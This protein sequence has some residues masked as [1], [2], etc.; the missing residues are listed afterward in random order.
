M[1][2]PPQLRAQRRDLHD[3]LRAHRMASPKLRDSRP[4]MMILAV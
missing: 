2:W 1:Q 4:E 3:D